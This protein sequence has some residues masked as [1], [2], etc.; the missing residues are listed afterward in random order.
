MTVGAY[1]GAATAMDKLADYY[2]DR[3][4]QIFPIIEVDA[5]RKVTIHLTKGVQMKVLE[6]SRYGTLASNESKR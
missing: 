3:A 1:A 6:G 4:D 2:L 5:M